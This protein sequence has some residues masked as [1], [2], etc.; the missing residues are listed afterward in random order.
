[1]GVLLVL[2]GCTYLHQLF[3]LPQGWRDYFVFST[4]GFYRFS[5]TSC[6]KWLYFLCLIV[7]L[8]IVKYLKFLV[9][10]EI[11]LFFLHLDFVYFLVLPILSDCTDRV[12]WLYFSSSSIWTSSRMVRLFCFLYIW[13]FLVVLYFL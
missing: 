7:V 1:V 4:F 8:L 3:E 10:D 2:N 6:N 11:I 5:C 13:F 12:K 9:D